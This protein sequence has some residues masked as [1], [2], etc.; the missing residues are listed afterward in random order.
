MALLPMTG[1]IS[2]ISRSKRNSVA[3]FAS[4]ED[5]TA[6]TAPLVDT[7]IDENEASNVGSINWV[8]H[9]RQRAMMF[10]SRTDRLPSALKKSESYCEPAEEDKDFSNILAEEEETPRR[11]TQGSSS[12]HTESASSPLQQG[13]S[14]RQAAEEA[15]SAPLPLTSSSGNTSSGESNYN[16]TPDNPNTKSDPIGVRVYTNSAGS[17]RTITSPEGDP[18]NGIFY[19][20]RGK[21]ISLNKPCR[22]GSGRKFKKCCMIQIRAEAEALYGD[23]N[24][25][26][27]E[28]GFVALDLDRS[29]QLMYDREDGEP[30][31]RDKK[32]KEEVKAKEGKGRQKLGGFNITYLSK[33]RPIPLDESCLCG[34]EINFKECCM[35]GLNEQAK[36]QRGPELA[37]LRRQHRTVNLELEIDDPNRPSSPE[38]DTNARGRSRAYTPEPAFVA[39]HPGPDNFTSRH[40][41]ALSSSLFHPSPTLL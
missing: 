10:S 39:A 30:E 2:N 8:A 18:M 34:S 16:P 32:N 14:S 13:E 3:K 20:V 15:A 36:E 21:P 35:P 33:G 37:M 38:S 28:R 6:D 31:A 19:I 1:T 11:R 25:L 17:D 41:S 29:T 12:Q 5:D 24:K 4:D 9:H 7:R 22:C 26:A 40:V 27:E 23:L